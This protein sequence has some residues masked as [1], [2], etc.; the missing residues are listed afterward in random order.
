MTLTVHA[1]DGVPEVR[2]GDDLTTLLREALASAGLALADGDV[3]V[4]TSKVVSKAEGLVR[5][6]TRDEAL[7]AETVRVV[8]R[9]GPTSIVR[10][11][12]GLTMAAA[13][14]DASNV[15][16]DHV[17]LL[18][19]DPD[20]SARSL[21]AR[22]REVTG[23]NVAVVVT[24]SAG[25]AWREGQTDI[26]IG[27]AGLPVVLDH[28][29]AVDAHGN[30]LAVTAPAVADEVAG[31]AELVQGKLSGR[32]FA[33]VRGLAH[34]VL[35]AGDDGPGAAALVRPEAGDLFGYGAREAVARALVADPADRVGFGA[36]ASAEE[37]VDLLA[38]VLG[39]AGRATLTPEGQVAAPDDPR[40]APLAFACGWE[41]VPAGDSG[42]G[43]RWR[44]AVP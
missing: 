2:A 9:R 43:H 28:R 11:R 14:I 39:G 16:R 12:H 27:A 24:D 13:G 3:A 38:R 25:R 23:A 10:T 18:P 1:L 20:L 37:L 8:A 5:P 32:P 36:V 31:A 17:V 21:R 33:L 26:A 7:A 6:G 29:G 44:P 34:L 30:E 22:L 42:V 4:V 40:V 35:P 41:R 15:E 19:R